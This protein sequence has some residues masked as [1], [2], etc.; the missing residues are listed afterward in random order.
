[1]RAN[2]Y[3]LVFGGKYGE[4]EVGIIQERITPHRFAVLVGGAV[5]TVTRRHVE[6]MKPRQR[7]NFRA[8]HRGN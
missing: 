5:I 6:R 1:M 7:R 3:V 8:L 4:P 2:S